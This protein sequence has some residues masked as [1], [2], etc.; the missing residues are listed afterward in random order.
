MF[1]TDIA[2]PRIVA[3]DATND[4]PLRFAWTLME[5]IQGYTL[6]D[7]WL[8][9]SMEKK[10][11]LVTQVA[12][13]QAQLFRVR[14]DSIGSLY[15]KSTTNTS[16]PSL[17]T[18]YY[19]FAILIMVISNPRTLC[20]IVILFLW[21]TLLATH[22]RT[23][24]GPVVSMDFIHASTAVPRGPFYNLHDWFKARLLGALDEHKRM[25]ADAK[26]DEDDIIFADSLSNYTRR[27][28]ELL[29]QYFSPDDPPDENVLFTHDLHDYNIMVN[30]QGDLLALLDW[31]FVSTVPVWH[32]CQYPRFLQGRDKGLPDPSA[33][34]LRYINEDG[35]MGRK[36]L[37]ENQRYVEDLQQYE[38]TQLRPFFLAEMERLEPGWVAEFRES[39][40]K[41]DWDM[42]AELMVTTAVCGNK[43][44]IWLARLE[45]GESVTGIM[46]APEDNVDENGVPIPEEECF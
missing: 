26:G 28:L 30:E 9:M 35:M 44:D 10:K 23:H 25:I 24:L 17:P 21:H 32:A 33:Y 12:V 29:P 11:A 41:K 18:Q 27:L 14:F 4:N 37:V 39:E 15:Q 43:Q 19:L 38:L 2:T 3:Y 42:V 36:K 1:Q 34:N 13:L 40:F 8:H 31:E 7:Q 20:C 46:S 45:R 6:A 16:I 22:F 5:Y